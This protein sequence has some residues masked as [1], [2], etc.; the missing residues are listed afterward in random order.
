MR[1]ISVWHSGNVRARHLVR[2]YEREAKNPAS[3]LLLAVKVELTEKKEERKKKSRECATH[4]Q[5]D[6]IKSCCVQ[7]ENK[8]IYRLSTAVNHMRF[9]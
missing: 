4:T 1:D 6:E 9:E 8:Y 7:N 3:A 5:D 2:V